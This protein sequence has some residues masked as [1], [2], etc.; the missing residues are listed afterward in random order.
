MIDDQPE[1]TCFSYSTNKCIPW[2]ALMYETA[3][4]VFV[5]SVISMHNVWRCSHQSHIPK[6]EFF[7]ELPVPFERLDYERSE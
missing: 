7:N 4:L 6:R 5:S 2:D 1:P 3:S